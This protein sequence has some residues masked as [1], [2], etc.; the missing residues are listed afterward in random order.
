MKHPIAIIRKTMGIILL[1]I[2]TC[3]CASLRPTIEAETEPPRPPVFQPHVT[4]SSSMFPS[5]A[6]SVE[7]IFEN[8]NQKFTLVKSIHSGD[9]TLPLNKDQIREMLTGEK[10]KLLPAKV[11][12][13]LVNSKGQTSYYSVNVQILIR[14]PGEN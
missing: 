13:R 2:L 11:S 4:I 1:T 3:R 9:W 5:D 10:E 7:L 14:R 12:A 6:K 8:S